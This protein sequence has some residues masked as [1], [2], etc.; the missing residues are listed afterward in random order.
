MGQPTQVWLLELNGTP[1]LAIEQDPSGS[2]PPCA[3]DGEVK[4]AML[5]DALAMADVIPEGGGT[6]DYGWGAGGGTGE[7]P[8][9]E[10][11]AGEI[12][13]GGTRRTRPAEGAVPPHEAVLQRLYSRNSLRVHQPE[14]APPPHPPKSQGSSSGEST[15]REQ[16]S[17]SARAG[18][19]SSGGPTPADIGAPWVLDGLGPTPFLA[20]ARPTTPVQLEPSCARRWRLGGC[21]YCPSLAE[22]GELWR[23]T[24]EARR[25]GG[26]TALSPSLDEEW[27]RAVARAAAVAGREEQAQA[28]EEGGADGAGRAGGPHDTE[29]PAAAMHR[30]G[31]A[32]SQQLL[33]DWWG[34][35]RAA[36]ACAEQSGGG[37]YSE[38][39]LVVRW[40]A[41]LC[42]ASSRS[43]PRDDR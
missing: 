3:R 24:A 5:A 7:I 25:A 38:S 8:K 17:R 40:E 27:A 6:A 41:M 12:P 29:H 32:W 4:A 13:V 42:A 1:S 19:A 28:D 18:G 34:A 23:A 20:A 39:C 15:H 30:G 26:W 37:R 36:P 11:V 33:T 21:R 22:V 35:A 14:N 43:S 9:G 16:G 31:T 10:A 2:T